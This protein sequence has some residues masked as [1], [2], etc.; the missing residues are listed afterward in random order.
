MITKEQLVAICPGCEARADAHLP[1]LT[2]AMQRYG[3]NT[4]L[5]VAMFVAQVLHETGGL[6]HMRENMNYSAQGLINTFSKYFKKTEALV[7]ARKPEMIGNRAYAN[8]FGNGPESSGDGYK[9]RGGGYFHLTFRDNYAEFSKEVSMDLVSKPELIATPE[10][11]S[12]SAGWFWKT[13]K[14][15][16]FAD[17]GD[18]KRC[19]A[20]LNGGFNG[21]EQRR[22][23]YERAL[24]AIK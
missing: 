11:A 8:R 22:L 5:R 13:R 18:L 23:Y 24:I 3:I 20:V 7:F 16:V 15:N 1:F 6:T 17:A 12:L 9:F 2:S 10:F 14:L 4:R 19:T 21:L